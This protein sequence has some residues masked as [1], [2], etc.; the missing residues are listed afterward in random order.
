MKTRGRQLLQCR[1]I[2]AEPYQLPA[3]RPIFLYLMHFLSVPAET[4]SGKSSSPLLFFEVYLPF[5][6]DII[7]FLSSPPPPSLVLRLSP[8]PPSQ[9]VTTFHLYLVPTTPWLV[10]RCSASFSP[11]LS[12]SFTV[13]LSL[14]LSFVGRLKSH[15]LC[16]IG[17]KVNDGYY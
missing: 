8:F 14:S 17:S 11:S 1:S 6:R 9:N 4:G 3:T 2:S 13:C 12:L 10:F 7:L 16:F 15:M 5:P